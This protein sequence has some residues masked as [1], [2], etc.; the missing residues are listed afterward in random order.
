MRI[1]TAQLYAQRVAAMQEQQLNLSRTELEMAT[2]KRLL[3]AADNPA[4]ALRA[5]QL[6][7]GIEQTRQYQ[8]NVDAATSRLNLEEGALSGAVNLLQ[9]IREL[10]VQ[11][12]NASLAPEDLRAIEVEVRE[13]LDGLLQIANTRD[14][15][16]EYLFSGY[17]GNSPAFSH[18]GS[19]N[20]TYNGDQGQRHLQI[21]ATR[22]IAIGDHGVRVFLGLPAT[23]GGVT[24]AFDMVHEF[25]DAL[26]AG[27]PGS[28]TLDD[29]D[30]AM[31]RI[32]AV[33]TEV[34]S[35]LN[36]AEDQRV[37]NDSFSLLMEQDKAALTDLDYAEAVSR[38]N[39][40]LLALQASQQLF[41][42]TQGL[43]LFNYLG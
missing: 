20:F 9:R 8:D 36:A 38:F 34:G 11:S 40:Q 23:G 18:D 39:Q 42:K 29:I 16:G 2:G 7:E 10:A 24:S 4:D 35:R 32:L 1:S 15:N 26:A 3:T 37:I 17:R 13:N 22:Q 14:A 19:G 28:G 33:R 25:A 5:L 31:E 43:S 6:G 12:L 27:A 30:A 21:S 41:A